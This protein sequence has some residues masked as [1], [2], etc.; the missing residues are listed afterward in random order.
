MAPALV[1]VT[2]MISIVVSSSI[3][4]STPHAKA[5]CEPPPCKAK[6]ILRRPGADGYSHVIHAEIREVAGH[7]A[8]V[9]EATPAIRG[10]TFGNRR[11]TT[12]D[13]QTDTCLPGLWADLTKLGWWGSPYHVTGVK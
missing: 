3:R 10:M 12:F 8:V 13:P 1:P 11:K 6:A 2:P 9:T 7:P 5:P 4:S